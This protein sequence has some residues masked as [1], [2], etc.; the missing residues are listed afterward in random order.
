VIRAS[1]AD[2]RVAAHLH[3]V[4]CDPVLQNECSFGRDSDLEPV[5]FEYLHVTGSRVTYG[6]SMG[7]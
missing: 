3:I 5:S 6:P 7:R 4:A 1:F 2:R